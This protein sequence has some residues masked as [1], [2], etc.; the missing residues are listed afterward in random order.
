MED[1]KLTVEMQLLRR[2]IVTV[3]ATQAL[4]LARLLSPT[5]GSSRP[6][7]KEFAE[8]FLEEFVRLFRIANDRM[9]EILLS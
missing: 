6:T 8:D 4:L 5:Q 2:T 3:G 9:N 7:S 1:Q